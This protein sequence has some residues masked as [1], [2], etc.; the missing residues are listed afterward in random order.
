MLRWIFTIAFVS[1]AATLTWAAD[2]AD[3]WTEIATKKADLDG[4]GKVEN[5][6][7]FSTQPSFSDL[8]GHI[9]LDIGD[10]TWTSNDIHDL[11]DGPWLGVID[12]RQRDEFKE[13]EVVIA[14]GGPSEEPHHLIFAYRA[15][16]LTLL[17]SFW[18][19]SP[20]YT[21]TGFIRARQRAAIGMVNFKYV[22]AEDGLSIEHVEQPLYALN[23]DTWTVPVTTSFPIYAQQTEDQQVGLLKQGAPITLVGVDGDWVLVRSSTGLMGWA[24]ATEI[25]QNCPVRVY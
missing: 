24:R 17:R 18:A 20:K 3:E 5:I 15:G 2:V 11:H 6:A 13:V 25:R 4:D 16:A 22:L 8:T 9:R 14:G 23:W 21:G 19:H 7:L 1:G 12:I 10:A